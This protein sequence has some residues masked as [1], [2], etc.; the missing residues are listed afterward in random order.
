MREINAGDEALACY[1]SVERCQGVAETE[2]AMPTLCNA[3][4]EYARWFHIDKVDVL[5]GDALISFLR[6]LRGGFTICVYFA[7]RII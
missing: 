7:V 1:V 5:E 2:R 6:Q 3:I 4:K